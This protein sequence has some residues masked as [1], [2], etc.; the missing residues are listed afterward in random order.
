LIHG[1]G[2]DIVEI[3]RVQESLDKHGL[4]FARRIL[5]DSEILQFESKTPQTQASFLAKRFAAKE[6]FVKALGTGFVDG[7][8]LTHIS[9][10]KDEL[11]KPSLE[12]CKKA[13]EKVESLHV[14]QC[15]LSLADE[16]R[17]AV[18]QVL[19]MKKQ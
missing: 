16:R 2:V 13:A 18:A 14:G 7:I 11:G 5:S 6:A 12:Y 15:F 17:Y 10:V 19:L 8:S 4:R 1:I 3:P 9:V